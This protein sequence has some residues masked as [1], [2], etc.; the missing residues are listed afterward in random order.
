MLEIIPIPAFRDNYIWLLHAHGHAVVVD[1]GDAR[2][3][4][5]FLEGRGLQ[6]D[7][8][9]VTHHH[10]DHVGGIDQLLATSAAVA[11][12]P[13]SGN[14]AFAHRPVAEGDAVRLEPLGLTLRV[15]ETPGHTLD[16]VVY[17]GDG[18]LFCG[19]T[20]FGCGCG[21][22]REGDFR[23]LYRSLQRL[24]A[25]PPLTRVYC[26]HEYTLHNIRFAREIDPDNL[27][28]QARE[29]ETQRLRQHDQSSLPSSIALELATNP[30]LRCGQPSRALLGK[31]QRAGITD[32]SPLSAFRFL[33][34]LRD[35]Y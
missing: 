23:Q 2:P 31:M 18:H 9:L 34:E 24:A 13:R 20:L 10:D 30:F 8:I 5:D 16:H 22:L 32:A 12:A 27:E 33:R 14:Y 35:N 4:R 15:M 28:L 17:Y 26:A 6:L 19:D 1:P 29:A 7:A 3:V 21:R 25:L 11:Y